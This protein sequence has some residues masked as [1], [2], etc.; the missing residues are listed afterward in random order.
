MD[1]VIAM[2]RPEHLYFDE[3]G[4]EGIVDFKEE[5]GLI[6]RYLIII[7]DKI[8]TLDELNTKEHHLIGIGEKV[9]ISF[10]ENDVVIL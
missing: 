7:G 8:I 4:V 1:N 10:N 3:S 6:T 9:K 5:L 2:I